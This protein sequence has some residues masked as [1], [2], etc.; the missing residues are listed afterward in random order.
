MDDV[1]NEQADG[2][3][4]LAWT[5]LGT[6]VEGTMKFFLSVFASDYSRSVAGNQASLVFKRLWD[7]RK[8]QLRRACIY[9]GQRHVV[10]RFEGIVFGTQF[11]LGQHDSVLRREGQLFRSSSHLRWLDKLL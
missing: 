10:L 11:I 6:L 3:M 4:I 7:S 2:R 8:G 9:I 5:N 1:P